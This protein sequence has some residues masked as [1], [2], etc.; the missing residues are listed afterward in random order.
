MQC[1]NSLLFSHETW[2]WCRAIKSLNHP[3]TGNIR[4]DKFHQNW[5]KEVLVLLLLQLFKI[6]YKYTSC[7]ESDKGVQLRKIL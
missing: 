2:I 1:L 6:L 4:C 5:M 3:T 7:I